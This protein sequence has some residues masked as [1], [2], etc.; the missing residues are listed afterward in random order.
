MLKPQWLPILKLRSVKDKVAVW[1]DCDVADPADLPV[2][3]DLVS[4]G[5]MQWIDRTILMHVAVLDKKT[6]KP[7]MTRTGQIRRPN[8][9]VYKLTPLGIYLCN[10]NRIEQH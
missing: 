10:E 8:V 2:I 4:S 9:D 5:I 1:I 7:H 3:S 6:G